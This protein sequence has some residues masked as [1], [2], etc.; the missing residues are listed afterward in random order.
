MSQTHRVALDWL[1]DRINLDPKI[2]IK[3]IDT[4]NQLADMLTKGNFTR[5]QWDNLLRF[6]NMSNF[7]SSNELQTMAKRTQDGTEEESVLTSSR[8]TMNLASTKT[9]AGSITAQIFVCIE[10]PRTLRASSQKLS[11]VVSAGRLAARETNQDLASTGRPVS[12]VLD[13]YNVD[14][15]WQNNLQIS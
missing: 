12:N 2:Q 1:F 7:S 3:Y 14:S 11:L 10:P 9:I 13:I 8:A 6:V 4:K 15:E 5:D